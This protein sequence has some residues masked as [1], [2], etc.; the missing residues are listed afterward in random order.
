MRPKPMPTKGLFVA[1]LA[2]SALLLAGCAGL[3]PVTPELSRVDP[4]GGYRFTN[5]SRGDGNSTSLLVVLSFSGGGTRAAAL[6]FGVLEQLASIE[7]EWEGR[8]RRLL[9]E[10]DAISAVSGG[11]VTAA[12]YALQGDRLF[13]EFPQR[14]LHRDIEAD[15]IGRLLNPL[16]WPMLLSD[17]SGRSE[18][19]AEVFDEHVFG[20]AT[21]GDLA[22]GPGRPF[23]T[24]TATDMVAGTRFEFVQEQFDLLCADLSGIRLSRAV[25]A[26]AA[27]PLLMSPVML[28]NRAG[29]CG[30]R[31]LAWVDRT[32]AERELS[33]RQF[34]LARKMR[35]YLDAQARPYIHL[36]DGALS[37]N[38]GLRSPLETVF[39]HGD[40]WNVVRRLGIADVRKVVFIAV[41]ASTAPDAALS[42]AA[43]LP[44]LWHTL[45]AFKDIPIDRYSYET[46]ELL[47]ANFNRWAADIKAQRLRVGD[48][49]GDDLQ[50]FLVDVD[51]EALRDDVEREALMRI[52]TRWSLD[53][54]AVERIRRSAGI[55]LDDSA[56]FQEL[57]RS[58]RGTRR[59]EPSAP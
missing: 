40:A 18:L 45:S 30:F 20:G 43:V 38:L 19:L 15:F 35:S 9:D 16:N 24:L 39:A 13:A 56:A 41:N 36:L 52:P 49:A 48:S 26:S 51:F 44:G 57:L 53:Q 42:R 33:S 23:V 5:V 3:A 22:S 37:D 31:D 55:L 14:F 54:S 11:S 46:K 8:R 50:F 1:C 29:S 10:V 59:A 47:S 17:L 34:H 4:H 58:L 12:S 6:A 21:F 32:L 27:V 28:V 25:A 7:V 2:A